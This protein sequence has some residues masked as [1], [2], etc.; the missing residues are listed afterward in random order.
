MKKI[1]D[2][3]KKTFMRGGNG[4]KIRFGSGLNRK[5]SCIRSNLVAEIDP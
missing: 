1:K 3:V 5:V 4:K 2:A